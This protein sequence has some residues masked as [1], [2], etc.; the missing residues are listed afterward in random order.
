MQCGLSELRMRVVLRSMKQAKSECNINADIAIRKYV[1]ASYDLATSSFPN[2][3]AIM[4]GVSAV[5]G[6][7]KFIDSPTSVEM[8][9]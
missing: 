2:R 7:I 4:R 5:L 6:S 3:H 9:L 1:F 8:L